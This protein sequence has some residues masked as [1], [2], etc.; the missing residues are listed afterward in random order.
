[1][2]FDGGWHPML[3]VHYCHQLDGVLKEKI[4]TFIVEKTLQQTKRIPLI[5][6]QSISECIPTQAQSPVRIENSPIRFIARPRLLNHEYPKNYNLH[7]Q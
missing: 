7:S 2:G 3:M 5:Q 1:M 4:K 6:S